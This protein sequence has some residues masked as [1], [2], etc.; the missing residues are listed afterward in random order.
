MDKNVER[1][2]TRVH[3]IFD[4][5]KPADEKLRV[6][7]VRYNPLSEEIAP[8][9]QLPLPHQKFV[10]A[11]GIGSGKSTELRATAGRIA[12]QK[13]VVLF[14]LRRHFE[15]TV[16]DPGAIDHLQPAELVGLLGLALI[17]AGREV[18][19]HQWGPLEKRLADALRGIAGKANAE[20]PTLDV[21]K[22]ASG[23]AVLVGG[24]TGALLAGPLG[25]ATGATAATAA[26]RAV[27]AV[28][29][30]SEWKWKIGLRG[31][32]RASD[33]DAPVREVLQATNA[34][35]DEIRRKYSRQVVIL[36]DG[37]DRVS[38]PETFEDLLVESSLVADLRCDLVATLKLGLV[39]RFRSRLSWC[40]TFDFT[41][42]PVA[43]AADPSKPNVHGISFFREL[44]A[45]RF[46]VLEIEPPI[47]D[48]LVE[49]LAYRSGGRLRDFMKLV[50]EVAVKAM[51]ANSDE[52]SR[53][54]VDDAIDTL[55]RNQESGLNAEHIR[56]LQSVL[57]DPDRKLP[58]GDVALELLDRQ[59]LLAYPNE[60][61]WYLPHT[62]LMLN[63]V[64]PSPGSTPSA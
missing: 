61:S 45:V 11:G 20:T 5:T 2:W 59:L 19:G 48:P 21:A 12:N 57:E 36:V 42:V 43:D 64:H 40:E 23:V 38:D 24:A 63:L 32:A 54:M 37:L 55:R 15:A 22:L 14:D 9:L 31:R 62:L 16:V 10:L 7:R 8:R 33:Q 35:L 46:G 50:R 60:T 47:D 4:P 39:Q 44:A 29:D 18:L 30:S 53:T 49:R 17:R 51:L 25:T 58:A 52:A 26:L 56:V 6:P 28:A 3:E 1:I 34:L 27:E 41:Y 13:L